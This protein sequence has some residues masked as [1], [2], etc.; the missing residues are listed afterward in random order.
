MSITITE[1]LAEIK[2]IG[3]RLAKKRESVQQYLA[4]Q[5]GVKDPLERDGGSAEFIKRE[6]QGI[7]DLENRIIAL[8]RGIVRAN[9]ETKI[10]INGVERSI[11][12]WLIWR[13][14]VSQ[15]QQSFLSQLRAKVNTVREQA[16]RQGQ[17]V[18]TR[19]DAAEK[20]TDIVVHINEVELAKEIETLE[21]TLGQLDG[22]LSLKNATVVI[23]A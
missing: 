7:A 6:R 12:E 17:N 3:K 5:E 15:G 18:V 4:R 13:R 19:D 2:T 14:D 16:K 9:A 22:Q 21:D 23:A 20:P 11:E 1:A 10:S 8:R